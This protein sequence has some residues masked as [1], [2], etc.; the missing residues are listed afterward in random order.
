MEPCDSVSGN[1]TA[2][3]HWQAAGTALMAKIPP[4]DPPWGQ[5]INMVAAMIR[6]Y[7]TPLSDAI[8]QALGV[9]PAVTT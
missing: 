6:S 8:H 5:A 1:N 7:N 3:L 2:S 4:F 9:F